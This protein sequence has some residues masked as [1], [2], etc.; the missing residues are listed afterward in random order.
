MFR[1]WDGVKARNPHAFAGLLLVLAAL[2]QQAG[3]L[4]PRFRRRVLPTKLAFAITPTAGR[5]HAGKTIVDSSGINGNS[6][7]EAVPDDADL[8]G[9]DLFTASEKRQRVLGVGH[10]V[11]TAHLPALAFAFAA[12]AEIK[13]QS[14]VTHA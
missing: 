3:K 14:R 6:R 11:E 2:F 4:R 9:I 1:D 10:L 12:A 7:A 5:N 8:L 13:A